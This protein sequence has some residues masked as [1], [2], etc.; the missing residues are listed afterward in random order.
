[1]YDQAR[2]DRIYK[3]T[4]ERAINQPVS[5][6]DVVYHEL[7]LTKYHHLPVDE[8]I[9][10]S[11]AGAIVNQ[12]IYID[13]D[14]RIIGRIYHNNVTTPTVTDPELLSL[15]VADAE[16][17]Y[18][19]YRELTKNQL[20]AFNAPGHIAWDWNV[21]LRY[22]TEGI[23][24]RCNL[25]LE[26]NTD[27]KSVE[28]L[29]GVLILI[30]GLEKWN[31]L[32]VS[33][34]EARGMTE[35][36]EICR[37]VPRYP[38]R[39]FHEAVQSFFMQYIVCMRENPHGGN[40]PGRLDY[41][42][43]PF[44]EADLKAGRCTLEDAREL[45]DELL[46]RI[47]ERIHKA[48]GWVESVVIGGSHP[49][50][51]SAINPLTYIFIEE[52]MKFDIT[53][54]AVYVRLPKDPPEDFV[55]LCAGYMKDG[56]NRA[57]LLSDESIT[58]AL[59]KNGV[60]YDDA[61]HYYC[62]G[63]ME[64]GIQGK[65]SDFL[66]VG[67]QNMAKFIELSVTGGYCLVKGEKISSYRA[68]GLAA[69]RD[70]ES[71]YGDIIAEFKR[72]T[73]IMFEWQNKKGEDAER[74]R[75]AHLVSSMIDSCIYK[76]RNMHGGGAKYYDYGASVIGFAN[77]SDSLYAIKKA[78]FDE[79]LCTAEELIAALKANFEGYESLRA[80]L[81]KIPKYGQDD[82]GADAMMSRLVSDVGRI[83]RNYKNRFGGSGKLVILT[84]VWA[85][86]CGAIL[87][88][89]AD[90]RLSGRTV[91]QGVT[92]QG[93]AMK[94]GITAAINSCTSIPHDVFAGGASTMWDLDE[95]FASEEI[96]TALFTSFFGAGGQI[97][98][99][100]TTDVKALLAARDNPDDYCN[101]I[102]RVGGFSARFVNLKKEIQD[103][104]IA[105]FKHSR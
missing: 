80:M 74:V 81:L 103:E 102:V 89:S 12:R 42:L 83:Y 9:A 73:Y 92:P 49:N 75:P 96:I 8:R 36:T 98:Q 3:K 22:G 76:G 68:R 52:N 37:R 100:N 53:H 17:F 91:A 45:I 85:E 43:W 31:E 77:A 61:V 35:M 66:F 32:H 95:S 51:I 16:A 27:A 62:G 101:L 1:M 97:F 57:Q 67:Y 40:S 38:A 23:R 13:E 88:A 60:P 86:Q 46:L 64:I 50:G 87:G 71:F 105:R 69:Y 54:P 56:G 28:F 24:E 39:T 15:K 79:K 78:V 33:E 82:V 10:R 70:F 26:R 19:G 5:D 63:C 94:C 93:S 29:N 47:D 90:G 7:A 11:M 72:I 48:D 34:L 84:F 20:L 59:V 21:I 44:L 99:G 30:E 18:P 55:K 25:A 41:Y 6:F 4:R 2:I 65:T 104:I 58:R 14:D